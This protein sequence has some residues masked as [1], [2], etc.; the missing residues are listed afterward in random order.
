MGAHED[1]KVTCMSKQV[2][3]AAV[4]LQDHKLPLSNLDFLLPPLDVN[5]FFCYKK[6]EIIPKNSCNENTLKH[7]VS[8]LKKALAQALA[9]FY[10]FAGEIVYN[11]AGE[12]EILCNN[13]GVEFIEAFA[14]VKLVELNLYNPDQSVEGKLVPR[15]KDAV[16]SVQVTE[17]KC[18]GI[19][20]ACAFDHRIADA[21][22]TNM[23]WVTWAEMA[24]FKPITMIPN[25]HRSLFSP[26]KPLDYNSNIYKMYLPISSLPA[27]N[28]NEPDMGPLITR[29]YTI[30]K[31]QLN[32]L[33][34]LCED[35]DGENGC[36]KKYS[37]LQCFSAI[38]WKIIASHAC[39]LGVD[40]L[41]KTS[42]M[43]IVVD[44]RV[45][46]SKEES[47]EK[48][49][50]I[51][52]YF[53]NVLS[54]PFGEQNCEDLKEMLIGKLAKL[55][56]NFVE[57]AAK[58]EHFLGLIDW[59]EARRPEPA[60]TKIYC[61]EDGD[62]PA[63]VMSSGLGFP[64]SKV[65]FGWGKPTFGSYHFPWG[66]NCGYVMPMPNAQENGDWVVYMHL[67]KEQLHYIEAKASHLFQPFSLHKN[68]DRESGFVH[69][70]QV[71]HSF[72]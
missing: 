38:L 29:V 54:I 39:E 7:K 35:K 42:M 31:W 3:A 34:A 32:N 57:M 47:S 70:E 41:N 6:E 23:F 50:A 43:G 2:V 25:L 17:L 45:R 67:H 27:P 24:T 63:F 30:S 1:F 72:G 61:T 53:G 33:Q 18:G 48:Q 44:G 66:G 14:D 19:V 5:V 56:N 60:V 21:Y 55:V 62:G 11:S 16:F 26:R 68:Y 4:P 69:L 46:L 49:E 10:P 28:P 22:S 52:T 51:S 12:P 71:P 9:Y 59:V 8:V 20:I 13:R 58:K 36:F 64:V 65:D 37:K 15:K 40:N